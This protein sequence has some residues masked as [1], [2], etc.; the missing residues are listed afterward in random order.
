MADIVSVCAFAFRVC[1]SSLTLRLF[2]ICL[3]CYLSLALALALGVVLLCSPSRHHWA[4]E[5]QQHEADVDFEDESTAA[6]PSAVP[7]SLST[8]HPLSQPY[9][10]WF[11]RRANLKVDK[12][13][14]IVKPVADI[15][16]LEDFWV[17]YSFLTR[18][19]APQSTNL[20]DLHLFRE[21]IMP[22]WEDDA[23]RKGGKWIC[24]LKKGLA[25]RLWEDLLLAVLGNHFPSGDEICGYVVSIRLNED[26]LAV[27]N[28]NADKPEASYPIRDALRRVLALPSTTILEYKNHDQSLRDHTKIRGPDNKQ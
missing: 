28:R 20:C 18:V 6:A 8:T 22:F 21:G 17:V 1:S 7:M 13:A 24:R 10:L 11:T 16:T 12:Y 25:P 23:N 5:T 4:T 19:G 2:S 15:R 27:W 9:T 26:S 3:S 14:D